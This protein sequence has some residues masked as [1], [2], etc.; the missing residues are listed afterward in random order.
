MNLE[1]LKK[2]I[3]LGESEQVEFK[4]STAQLSAAFETV[5]AFLNNQGGTVFIGVTDGGK[6]VGQQVADTTRQDIAKEIRKIEPPA[7]SQIDVDYVPVEQGRD[8]IVMTVAASNHVPCVY[9]GRPF[10][11]TQSTTTLMPQ[12][13]Y[14]QLIVKRGHLNYSWEEVIAHEYSIKDLDHDEIYKTVADGIRENRIPAI[15][16]RE[17]AREILTRLNLIEGNALKRAAVVL[18]AKQESMR[19]VQCMIKMAR[20]AGNDKLGNFIDNQQIYGNAFRLLAEAD[21]FLKRHLPIASFFKSD[22]FK[23][24][25][26]PA[27]PVMA[28]REALINAICHRDYA[29]RS[30]DIALAIYNNRLEIWN[31]GFLLDE[32]TIEDLKRKHNSVL[33]NKLIANVFYVRGMIEKWGSGTNKMIALCREDGIPEPEFGENTGGLEVVFRFKKSI[34]TQLKKNSSMIKLNAR[35]EII[36]DMIKKSAPINIK[37]IMAQLVN[38]PSRRMVLKDLNYLKQKKLVHT[39]GSTNNAVW[40]LREQT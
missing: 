8:I 14:E 33:R 31:S 29:D 19:F 5:C 18:Y 27:L 13:R 10:Q 12:H 24:I 9:D 28:V 25:D 11:R 36:L 32:M 1:Q 30:T 2:I 38:P 23:R 7:Q 17:N 6:I 37:Q 16:Q 40:I 15:A 3:Q 26:Q 20:F 35:Q 39:K 4:K 21:A 34:S 22:Q